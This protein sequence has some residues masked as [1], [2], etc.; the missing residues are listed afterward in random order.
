MQEYEPPASKACLNWI[1]FLWESSKNL[2]KSQTRSLPRTSLSS[3][4][5]TSAILAEIV[6]YILN[7]F[8]LLLFLRMFFSLDNWGV[9]HPD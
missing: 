2:V 1:H 3:F 8:V 7:S 6:P 9:E 4:V 5:F